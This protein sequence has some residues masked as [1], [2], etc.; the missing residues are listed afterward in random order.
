MNK[1]GGNSV[2]IFSVILIFVI[3]LSIW[4]FSASPESSENENEN[5]DNLVL[6][7]EG[8]KEVPEIP[9]S[10]IIEITSY[11]FSPSELEINQGEE[12]T[13]INK[14]SAKHWPAS[15]MHPTH[16]V[17]PNSDIKKCGTDEQGVI[18]DSCK[19]L[20]NEESWSFVFNEKGTWSYHDHISSGKF[21]KI[22]VK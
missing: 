12:V 8:V 6:N 15:A 10:N 18:F 22:V 19:G 4:Y 21:G 1:K 9:D 7:E 5:S 3:V 13:W 2:M 11:G 16:K 14:D 20:V 17:Y